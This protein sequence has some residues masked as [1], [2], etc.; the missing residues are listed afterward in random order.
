MPASHALPPRLSLAAVLLAAALPAFAGTALSDNHP[1]EAYPNDKTQVVAP[2]AYADLVRKVQERLRA[3]DFDPGPANGVIS[4]KTQAALAQFQLSQMLPASGMLDQAT[5]LALD[6]DPAAL[7]PSPGGEGEQS[8]AGGSTP[9]LSP[10][11]GGRT[12]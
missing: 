2:D 5:L 9:S 1:E 7:A 10:T 8:C 11:S 3:N 4:T 6:L 12:P